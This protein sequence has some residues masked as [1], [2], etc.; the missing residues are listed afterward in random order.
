MPLADLGAAAEP[1]VK[2]EP[3]PKARPSATKKK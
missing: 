2:A 3:K 1:K